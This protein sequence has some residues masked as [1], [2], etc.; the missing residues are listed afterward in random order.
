MFDVLKS[1]KK[2][3]YIILFQMLIVFVMLQCRELLDYKYNNDEPSYTAFDFSSLKVILGNHR[4]LGL[5]IFI[6]LYRFF[7]SSFD[8][9]AYFQILIYF[10]SIIFLTKTL[11]LI[12]FSNLVSLVI[13]SSLLWYKYAHH[14]F[15]YLFT[16]NLAYSF[17]NFTLGAMFLAVCKRTYKAYLLLG[18]LSFSLYQIRPNLAY[19]SLLIVFWAILTSIVFD[20]KGV[21]RLKIGLKFSFITLGPLLVFIFLRFLIV[22]QIGVVSFSG[23]NLSAHASYYLNDKNI[24]V[25][26]QNF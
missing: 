5:P 15:G 19:V 11:F 3:I 24:K 22:D 13:G 23:V 16:E 25:Y 18:F 26:F 1:N 6:S 17:L 21:G 2:V 10:A 7:L 20:I 12:G 8:Y 9:W 14:M 4:T